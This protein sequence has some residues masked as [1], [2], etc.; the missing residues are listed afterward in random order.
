MQN[1]GFEARLAALAMLMCLYIPARQIHRVVSSRSGES[2]P[3]LVRAP[4][5]AEEALADKPPLLFNRE[6]YMRRSRLHGRAI[7]T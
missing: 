3:V 6:S 7:L 5:G 2:R 4:F 1:I